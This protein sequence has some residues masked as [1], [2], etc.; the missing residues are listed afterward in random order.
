MIVVIQPLFV[1]LHDSG[2]T[3]GLILAEKTRLTNEVF[4]AL[5]N[6]AV[7]EFSMTLHPVADAQAAASLLITYVQGF[8]SKA[9]NPLKLLPQP[10]MSTDQSILK[11]DFKYSH[12]LHSK[13]R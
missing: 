12:I 7:I 8:A 2:D 3:M 11:G 6:L 4:M 9:V 10:A 1:G 5:Q 13:I